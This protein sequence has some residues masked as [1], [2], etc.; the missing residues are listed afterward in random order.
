MNDNFY[1]K[2]QK[3][4]T[5]LQAAVSDYVA[6]IR[7]VVADYYV[8]RG[9]AYKDVRREREILKKLG[10]LLGVQKIKN[11]DDPDF[12]FFKTDTDYLKEARCNP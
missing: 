8:E 5:K 2:G 3:I 1:R 9:S 6:E 7:H 4:D 11:S 10:E 12:Y